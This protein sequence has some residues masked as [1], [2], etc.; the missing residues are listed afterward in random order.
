LFTRDPDIAF[1]ER[2]HEKKHQ[3]N[4]QESE[5]QDKSKIHRKK[6]VKLLTNEEIV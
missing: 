6:T 1:P 3:V 5:G 2:L 4:F